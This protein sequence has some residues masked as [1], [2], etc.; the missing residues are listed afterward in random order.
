MVS[1]NVRDLLGRCLASL[2]LADEIIV[3]DNA[4]TDGS[5]ELVRQRFPG[6]TLLVNE[7]NLGFSAAVN[8][9]AAAATGDSLLL[10]NP[11]AAINGDTLER[12]RASLDRHRDADA[13]GFRQV[14][15]HGRFQLAV[16]PPA[17][18]I[19][20]L[21]RRAVQ[22]RLDAGDARLAWLLDRLLGRAM[23]VPWV[24]GS[25]LLVRREAFDRV[26]GFDARFFL[27]FEDIDF[28]LRL[29]ASGGRVVYYPAVTVVHERGASAS[30]HSA[31]AERAYRRSQ[32]YFWEKHRGA[33][34]RRAV[35]AY[36]RLRGVSP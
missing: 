25:S 32:L 20:D 9:A 15:S 8:Q 10:L 24:A 34:A 4:S 36:Q 23:P 14:D 5:V 12:M 30:G 18:L 35:A 17:S 1:F 22:R 29:R 26:D 19:L 11:D 13:L 33:W 16:G 21:L 2:D 6:V 7:A 28:C 27:Y 31:E 3:V